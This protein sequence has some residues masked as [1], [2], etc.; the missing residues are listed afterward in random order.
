MKSRIRGLL[1]PFQPL[2]LSWSGKGD[3]P[4]LTEA[5]LNGS[6]SEV[7]GE[8]RLCGF[9]LNEL[10]MRLLHPHDPH[11]GLFN[12][13]KKVLERLTETEE[14]EWWLRIFE[15]HLLREIG[16]ALILKHEA[17]TNKAIEPDF[18]YRYIPDFGA[19]CA[20]GSHPHGI[21]LKGST[22]IA[23]DHEEIPDETAKRECK[24]LMRAMIAQQLGERVLHSRRL[25]LYRHS[26]KKIGAGSL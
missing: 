13:Y 25:F 18:G 24:R 3:L 20:N 22:L 7:N 19:V 5:E 2:L 26:N 1:C 10:L 21:L 23:L 9:Y 16:Y 15:K 11:K 6:F 14:R 4:I 8:S 17:Q 12:Q